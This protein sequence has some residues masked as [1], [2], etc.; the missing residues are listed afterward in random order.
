MKCKFCDC[1][2]NHPYNDRCIILNETAD[3]EKLGYILENTDFDF[4]V[5]NLAKNYYDSL[6][7]FG[8]KR[9]I[10]KQKHNCKNRYYSVRSALT[11]LKKK[12]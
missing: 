10:Y 11:Y 9:V 7:N 12:E 8:R 2:F 6:D 5:N 4:E 1:E 3:K